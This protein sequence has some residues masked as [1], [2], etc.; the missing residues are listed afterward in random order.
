MSKKSEMGKTGEAVACAFLKA[1][2]YR[3]LHTNWRFG[4][5][6]LD[7]V[8]AGERELVVVEVKSRAPD[9][10]V[11]PELAVDH[12]KIRRIAAAADEYVIQFNVSLPVRFDVVCLTGD[13]RH[14]TV[15][16]HIE[17]AFLAPVVS[18]K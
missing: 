15:V 3:I 16:E 1:G 13:E 9:Y 14:C 7:I 2:G 11:A 4:R 17:D 12:V 8:A 5:Y 18:N 10:L 6:E